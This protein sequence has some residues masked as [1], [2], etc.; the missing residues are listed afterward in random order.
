MT[1]GYL[2]LT[3]DPVTLK[4]KCDYKDCKYYPVFDSYCI[5]NNE[6]VN[7]SRPVIRSADLE[8]CPICNGTGYR[9]RTVQVNCNCFVKDGKLCPI[10][11]SQT[12]RGF[13]EIGTESSTASFSSFGVFDSEQ[14]AIEAIIEKYP[15]EDW[16][17]NLVKV[18]EDQGEVDETSKN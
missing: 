12:V 5:K 13:M 9:D 15:Y 6:M 1:K 3:S 17:H 2:K 10:T 8:D 7:N 16:T 14:E 18:I 11:G 4:V